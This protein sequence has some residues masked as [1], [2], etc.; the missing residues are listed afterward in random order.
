MRLQLT[1][2]MLAITALIIGAPGAADSASTTA[3][4]A[5]LQA[6]VARAKGGDTIVL[7]PGDYRGVRL[8]GHVFQPNL[9]ID[10]RAASFHGLELRSIEGLTL[11]GGVYRLPPSTVHPRDGRTVFG[12][13]LRMDSVKG[14][15][16]VDAEVAGPGTL[17]ADG[18]FGEGYGVF[19]ARSAGVSVLR[20]RFKGFKSGVVLNRVDDFKLVSNQFRAMRSDG[21]QVGE[22]HRGLI[23]DNDCADTRI[24]DVEHPDCIQL[25]SRP[26]SPA[27]ADIVIR[28]NRAVGT[29][30]GAFLGN[31]VRDGVDDGGFDRIL[32][33]DN[34]FEVGY[35]N[36]ISITNG[37]NSIV[38]NN[39]VT[40]LAGAKWRASINVRGVGESK[41]CGNSVKA[42]AGKPGIRDNPCAD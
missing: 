35:P 12:Q 24:R 10:A 27:T 17:D 30:Q 4:P 37:R 25:W 18:P 33:E 6:A 32:I 29:M 26:T 34:V 41:V 1:G 16:V 8:A 31:H 3:S 20:S 15:E 11:R 28:R 36:G 5:T 19:V 14:V 38:R 13:A 9:V 39:K 23:E 40:T 42:A 2:L 7:A 22:G 21:I